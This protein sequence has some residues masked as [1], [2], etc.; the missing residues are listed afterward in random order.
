[1][2]LRLKIAALVVILASL[3][4]A[5]AANDFAD[6]HKVISLA[7]A[8]I[9]SG[10][11]A[12]V[13]TLYRRAVAV[14]PEDAGL[15]RDFARLMASDKATR[16]GASKAYSEAVELA[17]R[18]AVL[19]AEFAEFLA[20]SGDGVASAIQ[21]RRAFEL[22]PQ[23]QAALG[24][25]VRQV[26][27][28]GAA[29]VAIRQISANLTR[30]PDDL[31]GRLALGAL[32][33]SEARASDAL[34]QFLRALRADPANRLAAR[35]AA[36]AN[37]ALGFYG[38]AELLFSR[39]RETPAKAL[40]DKARVL[41]ASGRPEAA[42]SVLQA[43]AA[44]VEKEPEALVALSDAYRALG[45]SA[46][47]RSVLEN[48]V[49][50]HG[51]SQSP[52]LERLARS[53]WEAGDRE[54]S[55]ALCERLLQADPK[56]PAGTFCLI[57]L[58]A[59]ADELPLVKDANTPQRRAGLDQ[60]LGEA[61]LSWGQADE[62]AARLRRVVQQRPNSQRALL[63]LGAALTRVG[64]AAGAA[65]AFAACDRRNLT[66][67]LGLAEALLRQGNAKGCAAVLRQALGLD[68]NNF[69]A[70]L[71]L[72]E[73]SRRLGD[74]GAAVL[75]LT[76]LAR[77]APES[78]SVRNSLNEAL[79]SLDRPYRAGS[80]QG[81][82]LHGGLPLLPGD[83]VRVSFPGRAASAA[84]ASLDESGWLRLP[85][86]DPIN[87]RCMTADEL[88]AE[89][90]RRAGS[91]TGAPPIEVAP[92]RLQRAA[93]TVAGAVY[94][95]GGFLVRRG[96][97]LREGLM[98]ASGARPEAGRGVYVVRWAGTCGRAGGEVEVYGRAAA[99]EGRVRLERPLR[100]GDLLFVP[101][102]D[103]AF[104]TGRVAR[105]GV[106]AA[107]AGMTLRQAV[108]GAG[109][110]TEGARR[111]AVRLL[112]LLPDGSA[113]RQFTVDLAEVERGGIGD[114]V[115][116]PGDVIEVPSA[117]GG[118]LNSLGELLQRAAQAGGG[119]PPADSDVVGATTG[120]ER[121]P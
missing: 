111:E 58:G 99:E 68:D 67:L 69:R 49:S 6:P 3:V 81:E 94:T 19:A 5:N 52:A 103:A 72:A 1:M 32:L 16:A 90:V 66:A 88:A 40:A 105:P 28:L 14:W 102:A 63:A 116:R 91:P 48:L 95:P 108:E 93:L 112:R 78:K 80:R 65:S 92:V 73:A 54:S 89:I 74:D 18:D 98:L 33:L 64:D 77:R 96:L 24:G 35:A 86:L 83:T 61:A 11:A 62:A 97:D 121:R 43:G 106:V 59:P 57:A 21:Y 7:R 9:K 84:E 23:S 120:G 10:H 115:L 75:L 51:A 117:S 20:A 26:S 114:V 113:Y 53:H 47:E 101:E 22:D 55:R 87:A 110:V 60:E 41:L 15:R 30:T 70:G 4:T 109:G 82:S 36:E 107:R 17:P 119:P 12:D 100:A 76:D 45:D 56:N 25:Y 39:A 27:R 44:D 8:L 31:P 13:E 38:Q 34:D 42:L 50:L 46:R 2:A 104:V 85:R 37:L 71:L 118:G 79:L 29:P